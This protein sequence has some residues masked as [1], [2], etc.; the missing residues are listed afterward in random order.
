M[1]A[2]PKADSSPQT[3]EACIAEP[4]GATL[5]RIC[6]EITFQVKMLPKWCISSA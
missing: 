1:E 5:G 4:E 6:A 3:Q 2:V